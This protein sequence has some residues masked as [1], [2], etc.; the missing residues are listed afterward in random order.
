MAYRTP[1]ASSAAISCLRLSKSTAGS[2][3]S[4]FDPKPANN[5]EW[6][7]FSVE[8]GP[9]GALY[10][11]DWHDADICGADVHHHETGRIFRLAPAT[12]LAETWPGRY[13]DL[14]TLPDAQLVALQTSRSDRHARRA[15][16]ILQGRA[17]AG[18]LDPRTPNRL[19]QLFDTSS[20]PDWRLRA[21]W[22]CT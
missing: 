22:A 15:R 2:Y 10:V 8:I 11:L 4:L 1:W 14:R 17:A 18:T 7:G 3:A 16:I 12:S 9:D 21:M 6:V 5:A 20:D 19:R 13:D